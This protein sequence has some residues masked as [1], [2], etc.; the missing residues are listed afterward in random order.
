MRMFE[1]ALARTDL[2]V[3]FSVGFNPRPK[4]SLPLPRPVGIATAVDVLAVEFV[5]PVSCEETLQQLRAQMPD[6]VTLVEAWILAGNRPM[7]PESATYSLELSADQIP[8]VGAAVKAVLETT[9]WPIQRRQNEFGPSK[10]LDLRAYLL[11]AGIDEHRL[12]WT[13]RVTGGGSIRPSEFLA[14]VGLEPESCQH[15]VCRTA[16]Q[17][18]VRA[19]D[20]QDTDSSELEEQPESSE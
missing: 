9:T 1:R 19:A 11:D 8:L 13:V 2:P 15:N 3:R 6:G 16:I 4:L 7:Q 20:E 12:T 17:W 14:A 18:Q 5:S 10:T